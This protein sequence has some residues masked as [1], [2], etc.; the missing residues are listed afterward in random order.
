MN[1]ASIAQVSKDVLK[2]LNPKVKYLVQVQKGG[3]G[4]PD[5]CTSYIYNSTLSQRSDMFMLDIATGRPETVKVQGGVVTESIIL[6]D[7]TF[8]VDPSLKVVLDEIAKDYEII[9]SRLR[10]FE[11]ERDALLQD[12]DVLNGKIDTLTRENKELISSMG[13][14]ETDPAPNDD[15]NDQPDTPDPTNVSDKYSIR[16]LTSGWHDVVD[17]EGVVKNN[18]KLRKDE[19]LELIKKLESE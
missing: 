3:P 13:P 4:K 18:K 10:V 6:K 19:A 16:T 8:H 9:Q 2:G 1:T 7:K 11:E 12:K 15:Q 17:N 14:K 5:V